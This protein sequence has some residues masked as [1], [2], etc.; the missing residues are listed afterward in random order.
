M[1]DPMTWSLPLFRAFGIT[2]RLHILFII[3]VLGLTIRFAAKAPQLWLELTAVYFGLLFVAV[4]LHE[5]GHCFAARW[6]EG[7]ANEI[8]IW[9]LGG[10]AYV[11]VP[12]QPRANFIT[13]AGGPAV[14]LLLC[15]LCAGV[16]F[17]ASYLPNLNPFSDPFFPELHNFREGLT[18]VHK[19][20]P[21]FQLEGSTEQISFDKVVRFGDAWVLKENPATRVTPMALPVLPEWVV[22]VA[23]FFWLNWFLFLFNLIPA[24]PLDGGRLLQA[25]LWARNDFRQGTQSAVYVGYAM[26]IVMCVIAFVTNETLLFALAL[27]MYLSCRQQLLALETGGEESAFGYDFS[28]GYTSLERD[29]EVKP[30]PKRPNFIKRWLLQ[31]QARRVQREIEQRLAEEARMDELLQKIHQF[32]KESLTD[33]ERRFMDRV[34]ARYRNRSSE[35]S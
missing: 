29:E 8:L 5:F 26:A 11:E 18:A 28:Q 14:N 4:L 3:I 31:R 24:F 13:A 15:I 16:L 2:V 17:T 25:V 22:W 27:F 1:R 21:R 6:V 33:E 20:D 30:K 12:H 7:D 35:A 10:L 32:G 19:L 9:P 23:R 34:S